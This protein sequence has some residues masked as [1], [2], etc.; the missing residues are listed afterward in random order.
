M[1]TDGD[2]LGVGP[3]SDDPAPELLTAP[4][5]GVPDVVDET[6]RYQ[7]AIDLLAGGTGP[8]AIDAERAHAFRYGQCAY[9]IQLRRRGSGTVLI[10]PVT[11]AGAADP[12]SGAGRSGSRSDR[13]SPPS[14]RKQPVHH[15]SSTAAPADLSA[16]ADR[17]DDSEW[18]VHAATQDLPCLAELNLMPH[19]LFD[20][21]LAA[22]LLGYP[23]VNLGTLMEEIFGIR[24]L[25]EHSAADWSTRPLPSQWLSYA[26]LDV[27]RLIE[28]REALADQLS[29]AGKIAW[30]EQE[31]AWLAAG[32]GVPE[33]QRRD[34]WRRTSGLHRI[35]SRLGL[36]IVAQLWHARDRIACRIDLSPGR[37][38]PDSGLIEAAGLSDPNRQ[39]IANLPAFRRRPARRHLDSWASAVATAL[40][41]PERDLP[42][43]HRSSNE[44]PQQARA[45]SGKDPRAAARLQRV[46]SG[47]QDKAV[48]LNLPVANLLTPDHLR[49]LL[50]RPPEQITEE[51]VDERLAGY[52]ARPWQ[53]EQT[54]PLITRILI[55]PAG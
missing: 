53:R 1:S 37:L 48:E 40:Q 46:R 5:E 45:W 39:A 16:L 8:V 31:F 25:K 11:L 23:R 44:P 50:W 41:M 14:G 7:Q 51:T 33:Q 6:S 43:L 52:G 30:A 27:E 55:D 49:R 35:R 32:A 26:A 12:D 15:P 4:A 34:P 42:P 28:L 38:L 36:A 9:L 17:I 18:I 13:T 29:A 2:P 22:R 24:L 47:L 3:S 21:E 19:R 20:T 54:V 10:D